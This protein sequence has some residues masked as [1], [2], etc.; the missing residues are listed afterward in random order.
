[1][2][3][4][5]DILTQG[6]TALDS[7]DAP[8][9]SQLFRLGLDKYSDIPDARQWLTFN[10]MISDSL[11]VGPEVCIEHAP[12][13]LSTPLNWDVKLYI[14][15]Q[16]LKGSLPSSPHLETL[17]DLAVRTITTYKAIPHEKQDVNFISCLSITRH[18]ERLF[19]AD[20]ID[21][22]FHTISREDSYPVV[23]SLPSSGTRAADVAEAN[24]LPRV[25]RSYQNNIVTPPREIGFRHVGKAYSV[26][27]AEN[28]IMFDSQGAVLD[29]PYGPC[30][31]FLREILE[32]W[33]R[34]LQ[35]QKQV[36]GTA[37]FV[38]D[39]FSQSINYCHWTVDWMA[40]I[41]A[42]RKAGL[43][44]DAVIGSLPNRAPFQIATTEAVLDD[45]QTYY[46]F[47][48]DDGLV[49]IED[50]Y[51]A[52]NHAIRHL[53]H[54]LFR[55]DRAL[56][57]DLRLAIRPDLPATSKG[58]RLYVPRRQTRRV[59]NEA[60]VFEIL[61][62]YGFEAIDTDAMSFAEQVDTFSQASAVAAPHG[63]ALTNILFMPPGGHLLE[64]FPPL[65]GSSAFYALAGAVDLTY[66]CFI[67]D[68]TQGPNRDGA[69]EILFNT[70]DILVDCAFVE[71]WASRL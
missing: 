4:W 5:V 20:A 7:G 66:S 46:G 65:A 29:L 21:P 42:A 23:C 63:A 58:R 39:Y 51:F 54:P 43:R 50:L 24:R 6:K 28:T 41:V 30:P 12:Y 37:L 9:A 38:G 27:L 36:R 62:K 64:L 59:T 57:Q 2:S 55:G 3:E 32:R 8:R 1:M 26:R 48:E 70:G 40:R 52:D 71:R 16:A 53:N 56:A 25:I 60:E 17:R 13:L 34:Q 22:M 19:G 35:P 69:T 67:D 45:G 14:I 18:M 31:A 47:S 33:F 44:F 61:K 49:E 11:A 68:V 15:E 10:L